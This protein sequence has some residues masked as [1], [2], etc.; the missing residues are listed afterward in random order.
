[1]KIV[2]QKAVVMLGICVLSISQAAA[3]SSDRKSFAT[4]IF[5]VSELSHFGI[6][7][8]RFNQLTASDK[9]N[10]LLARVVV[11]AFLR[12]IQSGGN[13]FQHIAPSL[14]NK[15]NSRDEFVATVLAW[16]TSLHAVGVTD[17]RFLHGKKEI[18]LDCFVVSTSE[19]T[20]VVNEM[21]VTLS[22]FASKWRII[23][24][25]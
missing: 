15:Y 5:S 21:K 10:L 13:V 4:K 6:D 16:E 24:I 8:Q 14:A 17:F 1:M 25:D 19:G 7:Q 2:F 22:K 9:S 3:Q 12:D 18:Q 20:M 23:S 11:I